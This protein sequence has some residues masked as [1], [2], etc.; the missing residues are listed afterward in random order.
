MGEGLERDGSGM[1]V[2]WGEGS[3][4]EWGGIGCDG[5]GHGRVGWDGMGQGSSTWEFRHT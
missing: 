3:Q 4:V 1:G 2:G 5:M